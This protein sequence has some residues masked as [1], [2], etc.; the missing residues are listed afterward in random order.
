[1]SIESAVPTSGLSFIQYRLSVLSSPSAGLDQR[2]ASLTVLGPLCTPLLSFISDFIM[3]AL[4]RSHLLAPFRAV[5]HYRCR[6]DGFPPHEN[7]L[8]HPRPPAPTAAATPVVGVGSSRYVYTHTIVSALCS[9]S[10]S[11]L[12]AAAAGGLLHWLEL[13]RGLSSASMPGP[14]VHNGCA[15]GAVSTIRCATPWLLKAELGCSA[16]APLPRAARLMS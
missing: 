9:W 2:R 15:T 12:C 13:H 1:M 5:C 6:D 7:C 10:W 14:G 11:W 4:E 8:S 16:A 3:D